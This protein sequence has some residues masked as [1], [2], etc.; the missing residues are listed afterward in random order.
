ML[1]EQKNEI[2]LNIARCLQHTKFSFMPQQEELRILNTH[3]KITEKSIINYMDEDDDDILQK[4][5]KLDKKSS[6][7]NNLKIFYVKE[8]CEKL[9][10]I[11][12]R[13][14]LDEDDYFKNAIQIIKSGDIL[15]KSDKGFTW[16]Q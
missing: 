2:H 5:K 4:D 14:N 11:D 1:I 6:N 3:L 12:L 7:I 16:E 9:K 8:L 10:S 15:K 13:L